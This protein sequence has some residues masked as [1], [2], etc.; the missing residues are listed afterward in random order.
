MQE[1]EVGLLSLIDANKDEGGVGTTSKASIGINSNVPSA[2]ESAAF[3][4]HMLL[5]VS[6]LPS[7]PPELFK[8]RKRRSHLVIK[9]RKALP[10][11]T[12]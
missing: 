7:S 10:E 2:F 1:G 4:G 9:V 12:R 3:K 11:N 8:G 5:Y 6:G